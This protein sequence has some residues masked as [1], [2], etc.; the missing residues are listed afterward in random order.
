[1][2]EIEVKNGCQYITMS[3]PEKKN[4]LTDAMYMSMAQALERQDETIACHVL[5]GAGGGFTAGNDIMDFMRF[6]ANQT[7]PEGVERFLKALV[8]CQQPLIAAVEGDAIGVGTT[9]L[10]HCDMVIAADTARLKTPFVDL[11]LV[12]EAAAS[13]LAPRLMGHQ[14][15]FELLCLGNS[16]SAEDAHRCGLVNQIVPAAQL[17]ETVSTLTATIAQ[18]PREALRLS[19]QLLRPD[20]KQVMARMQE[21]IALFEQRLLSTEAQQAFMKFMSKAG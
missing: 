7:K 11:G 14:K 16:F 5:R 4:A 8:T 15:A 13:L 18:K 3:R 17:N 9:M 20:A 12:P 21:E 10:F 19:R 2:I 6:H 1:M